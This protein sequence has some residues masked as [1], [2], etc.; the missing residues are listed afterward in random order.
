MCGLWS[1]EAG[2]AMTPDTRWELRADLSGLVLR[3]YSL[4][5]R[6]RFHNH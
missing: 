3:A 1:P 2:L 6:R 5:R 4:K